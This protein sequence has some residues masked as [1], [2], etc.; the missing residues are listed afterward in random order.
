MGIG[1]TRLAIAVGE[2]LREHFRSG[3]VFVPLAMVTQPELVMAGIGRAAGAELAGRDTPLQAL[4]DYFGDGE[5]LLILDNLEHLVAAA[6]DLDEVLAHCPGLA[7][8]ATSLTVL[9]LRAEWVFPVAALHFPADPAAVPLDEVA[10]SPAVALFIDRARAVR[11]DFALTEANAA[12]VVEICRRLEGM[13]LAI[14][15]AAART[16]LLEPDALLARL[17]GSLDAL[18]AGT[19][20][21]PERQQ[22]LRATV[23]WSVSLLDDAE[24]SLLETV[25]VFVDGW[26]IDAAAAVAGIDEERALE[27]TDV[28]VGHSLIYLDVGDL[29]RRSRMLETIREF[30]AERLAARPDAAEIRRR[31][32]DH[33][34]ALVERAD[35]PMRHG[36]QNEWVR[37]LQIDRGN[38]AAAVRW[39]VDHD[40]APLPDLFRIMAPWAM[41]PFLGM[42]VDLLIEARSLIDELMP[43]VES[44]DAHS[45]TELFWGAAVVALEASDGAGAHAAGE[46]LEPLLEEIDDPY[47]EAVS[48]L[49]LSWNAAIADDF[50][51]GVREAAASL[52]V[53]R[54]LDEPL[55]IPVALI[56][57]GSLEMAVGRYDDAA[58]HLAE[59]RDESERLANAWLAIS[60][61]VQLGILAVTR[62]RFDDA[63]AVLTDALDISLETQSTPSLAL[64]L[65]AFARL[66]FLE[67]DAERAALLA[68]ATEGLRRRAGIRVWGSAR[69]EAEQVIQTRETLGADRF[70]EVFAAGS[71]L[72]QPGRGDRC[73]R[74]PR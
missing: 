38:L 18:G 40:R 57:L 16:R 22:T 59:G 50:Q 21:L 27:L 52:E 42:P 10:A 24:R 5:W 30:V 45:R 13:P 61:R 58:R 7:I 74:P 31:H 54:R 47:L 25:A 62:A 60:S 63:W 43:G 46:R 70:E 19:V 12:E 36:R 41:W 48:R 8:L 71:R 33:Y 14:E 53:L 2:R 68:G 6:R 67:G 29:G 3:V 56:T 39:Y 11:G 44:L 1:K 20:D 73:A 26:T 69:Q 55:W 72:S 28:L 34:R 66:A 15:L 9:R 49:V 65:A 35:R 37:R 17:A 23:E 51:R 64:C 4:I 32:A